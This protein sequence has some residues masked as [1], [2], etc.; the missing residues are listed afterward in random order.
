[1]YFQSSNAGVI[2][3]KYKYP[4]SISEY[5]NAEFS[6]WCDILKTLKS[7]VSTLK[8]KVSSFKQACFW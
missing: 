6:D 4:V 1:M 5:T 2:F 7:Q 8:K 3:K